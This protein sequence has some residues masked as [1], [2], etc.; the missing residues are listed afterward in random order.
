MKFV[1]N[2]TDLA[3]VLKVEPLTLLRWMATP[4]SPKPRSDGR[5]P[6]LEWKAWAK[7]H[8]EAASKV[9]CVREFSHRFKQLQCEIIDFKLSTLKRDYTRAS[10]V[11]EISNRLIAH[12][13]GV[14]RRIHELAPQLEGLS[15]GEIEK[16]LRSTEDE[17]MGSIHM[18][19]EAVAAPEGQKESKKSP[20]AS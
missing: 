10:D 9:P 16:V 11:I 8:G 13:G 15:I 6:V 18:A 1:R 20:L 19:P 14:I 3:R 2:Q 5:H 7:D 12:L 4:G 17:L